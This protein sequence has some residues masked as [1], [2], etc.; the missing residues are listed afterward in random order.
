[1][2]AAAFVPLGFVAM[3]DVSGNP[4]GVCRNTTGENL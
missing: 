3:V 2:D 4:H 1:V